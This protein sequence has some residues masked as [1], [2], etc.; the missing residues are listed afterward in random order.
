MQEPLQ[1]LLIAGEKQQIEVL[2]GSKTC[3]IRM[4]FRNYK[5]EKPILIGCHLRQWCILT[6]VTFVK[7]LLLKDLTIEMLDNEGYYNLSDAINNLSK[8][9]PTVNENSEITYLEWKVK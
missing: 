1:A 2:N 8:Y 3:S 6:E 5:I 4:G 7:H 9:Y